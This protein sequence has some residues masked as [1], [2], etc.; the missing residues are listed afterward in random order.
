MGWLRNLQ[1]Q[2]RLERIERLTEIPLLAMA[3][4]MVPLLILPLTTNLAGAVEHWFLVADYFIWGAFALAFG[5]K[6]AV[7]PAR[8]HYVKTHPLEVAMVLVPF[9][10]PLRLF[11]LVSLLRLGVVLGVDVRLIKAL[12]MRRGLG[13]AIALVLIAV[14]SGGTLVFLA[15]HARTDSDITSLWDSYWWAFVTM[16]T[17]GYGDYAPVSAVGRGIA[18]F[19]MIFGIAALA[20][21]TSY[22][23]T[24][25]VREPQNTQDGPE[26]SRENL[27][28]E[29]QAAR[30]VLERLENLLEQREDEE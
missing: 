18:V 7:A 26:P 2:E 8:W 16:T 1:S 24:I 28:A 4:A 30:A 19:L 15:E 9:L 10:R 11:R 12:F 22:V 20:S 23:T 6:L 5:S 21:A 29:L 3:L 17:V 27:L 25:M 13:F 14:V